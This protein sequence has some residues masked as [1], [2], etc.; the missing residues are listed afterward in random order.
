MK[1]RPH[2]P[3]LTPFI[4]LRLEA[5]RQPASLQKGEW[6]LGENAQ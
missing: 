5:G 2:V 4:A 3:L 6:C 1:I